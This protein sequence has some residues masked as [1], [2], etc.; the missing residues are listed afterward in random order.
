MIR[1]FS[2]YVSLKSVLLMLLESCL[3]ALSLV[4]AVKLRFW[5]NPTEYSLYVAFPDFAGQIAIVVAVCLTC[6]YFNDLYDL[7]TGYGPVE[8]V[9]RVQQSLGAASLLLGLLYFLF[10]SLLLSR[11]AF[12]IGM[13]LVTT[14]VLL[15]RKLL[16]R[17]WQLSTTLQLVIILGTGQLALELA[18]EITCR[19][20]LG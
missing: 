4:C 17:A 16:D 20:D 7:R 12:L 2:Q 6:F 14:L 5:N 8:R 15:A 1:I 18:R 13:L 9:L 10:P 19:D 3:I 11:V